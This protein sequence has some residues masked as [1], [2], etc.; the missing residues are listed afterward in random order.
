MSRN[1]KQVREQM[2]NIIGLN[3]E[4]KNSKPLQLPYVTT[5][6]RPTYTR[7]QRISSHQSKITLRTLVC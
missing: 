2:L 1:I 3:Q 4:L 7:H 6:Q 5:S